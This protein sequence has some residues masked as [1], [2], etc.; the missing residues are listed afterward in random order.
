MLDA[1]KDFD[2]S[3]ISLA[4]KKKKRN[5]TKQKN[6]QYEIGSHDCED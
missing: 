5:K 2:Q 4:S 1:T 6:S 3:P